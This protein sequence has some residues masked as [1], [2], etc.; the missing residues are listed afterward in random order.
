MKRARCRLAALSL[1]GFAWLAPAAQAVEG[2]V[3]EI[4]IT[5]SRI[6]APT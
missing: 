2:P 4:V 6:A 1:A 5:G 3:E